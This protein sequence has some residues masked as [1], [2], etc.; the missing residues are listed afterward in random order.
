MICEKKSSPLT[1]VKV[2]NSTTISKNLEGEIIDPAVR[3]AF[4]IAFLFIGSVGNLLLIGIVARKKTAKTVYEL[5][6]LNLAV[7]DL[8]LVVLY[9]GPNVYSF[10]TDFGTSL[11]Y[12]K[13]LWPISTYAFLLEI[14]SMTSMAL[15]RL[16]LIVYYKK[17][18]PK[19]KAACIWIIF[20]WIIAFIVT[21]PLIVVSKAINV[22]PPANCHEDWPSLNHR[23]AY[24]AVLLLIQYIIPLALIGYAYNR[25][26]NFLIHSRG[27]TRRDGGR[28]HDGRVSRRE[29]IQ[30]S[31]LL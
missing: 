5:F 26:A 12:C 10:I 29:N 24:T 30:V 20:M 22:V 2:M 3:V 8:L 27:C 4:Y 18:K 25:I 9:I 13:F 15:H 7:S 28:Q 23:R 17:P 11:F 21:L 14:F 6:V 31:K 1:C 19:K 16:W